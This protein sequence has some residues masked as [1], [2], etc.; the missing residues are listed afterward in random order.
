VSGD[1]EA[2]ISRPRDAAPTEELIQLALNQRPDLKAYRLGVARAQLEWLQALIEP[3]NQVAWRRW[4]DAMAGA[5]ARQQGK[6]PPGKMTA[7]ISLPTTVRNKAKLKRALINV[8]QARTELAKVEHEVVLDVRRARLEYDQARSNCDRF[9]NDILPNTKQLRDTLFR[10]FRGGEVPLTEYLSAQ[11]EYN[12]R[13][14]QTVKASVRLRRSA[15]ALNTAV[16]ARIM[17]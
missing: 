17:P 5:G 16:G 4:P 10:Q 8:Q 15:L 14:L 6:A 13:V 12:D 2:M 9:R 7:L 1:R 11:Q 3:L